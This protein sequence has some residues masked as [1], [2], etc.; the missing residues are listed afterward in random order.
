MIKF[1]LRRVMSAQKGSEM[2]RE[3][4]LPNWGTVYPD[5][6]LI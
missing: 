6:E 2:L 1:P 3:H 5:N 4:D